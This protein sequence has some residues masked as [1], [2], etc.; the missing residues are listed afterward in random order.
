MS[1][2]ASKPSAA[3]VAAAAAAVKPQSPAVRFAAQSRGPPQSTASDDDDDDDDEDVDIQAY[4]FDSEDDD[5]DG[6]AAEEDIQ[7]ADVEH[8]L[9]VA[10]QDEVFQKACGFFLAASDTIMQRMNE[11]EDD[12][13]VV[14]PTR[15]TQHA[16]AAF[17]YQCL[18]LPAKGDYEDQA[19]PK[20]WLPQ[21]K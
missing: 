20:K 3:A 14:H 8:S 19:D 5:G 1:L 12:A 13:P 9:E 16:I 7:D 18:W 2:S 15:L 21:F 6:N 4:E 10:A 17:V 11:G